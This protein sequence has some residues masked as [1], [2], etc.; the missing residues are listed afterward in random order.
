MPFVWKRK[1]VMRLALLAATGL[2]LWGC[3]QVSMT[4]R[5]QLILVPDGELL[6]MSD[7]EYQKFLAQ[8]PPSKD[9]AAT[10]RIQRVGGRIQKA[11]E[12]YAAE[13]NRTGD[14][15]GYAW[16]FN[17]VDK[18]QVNAWC[19]PGGKVVFYTGILPVCKDDD[20]IAVVMG[21]E[22]AHAVAR[23]GA[24]QMSQQMV[25]QMGGM[26]LGEALASESAA[27]QSIFLNVYGVGTQVGAL[28]PFSRGME[29][30]A[31]HMGLVF[32]A[33]AGYNPE[34]AVGFWERM[35]AAKGGAAGPPAFLSTH[36]QD[37]DRIA[38]IKSW[39][40]EAKAAYR[41]P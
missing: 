23:H 39:M 27:T 35:S 22:V 26:A 33:M 8:N 6:A 7:T 38:R 32:M 3:S 24:E 28:L 20:G 40:P 37:A 18:D 36:P 17:L 15:A 30:E 5:N 2:V 10:A 4:G 41:A 16:E 21:H 1:L 25:V 12:R 31:D 9:A 34:A 13:K 11:V 29:S 19:M 14:L